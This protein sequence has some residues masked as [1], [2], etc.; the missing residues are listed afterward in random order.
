MTTAK[1]LMLQKGHQ[2]PVV[3][4][5]LRATPLRQMAIIVIAAAVLIVSSC[6]RLGGTFQNHDTPAGTARVG[7]FGVTAVIPTAIVIGV[8]VLISKFF[9]K[10]G[11]QA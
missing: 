2:Q 1:G 7:L 6:A 8:A 11:T 9:R 10:R 5:R 3:S 4:T